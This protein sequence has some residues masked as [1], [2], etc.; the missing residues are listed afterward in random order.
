MEMFHANRQWSTRP[1]D[2]KFTSLEQMHAVTKAYAERAEE[3]TVSWKDLRIEADGKDV[4]LT[5]GSGGA[6]FTHYAFGQ[7]CARVG[8]PASYLR[9]LPAT[10]AAQNLNYGLKH[11]REDGNAQLLMHTNGN[12][13]VRAV[14]GEGYNRFWN[15]EVIMRLIDLSRRNHLVPAAPTF[16]QS[17][18]TEKALFASDHDMF[19]FLMTPER[20]VIDPVGKELYRG[21]IAVNSE[22]GDKSLKFMAFYFR[23]V[24]GNFIIWGA[25]QLVEVSMRHVGNINRKMVE[26]IVSVRKYLDADTT[27]E[28]ARFA[29]WSRQ[30]AG[31][32]DELLDKLFGVRSLGLSR[33]ALEASYD[34]V[35]V[36]QD[37]D[38]R[39]PWGIAQGIT[40]HSQ[41]LPYADERNTL[42]RA[43]GRLLEMAF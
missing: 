14:T 37:G 38:P 15:H 6:Q 11:N 21:I 19:A 27:L 7:F 12:K 23:D 20:Q 43:A 18:S 34:A 36:E 32:K 24:C 16:R 13:L 41:M 8:A 28:R 2:Q 22:V 3:R 26:A 4:Y 9:L 30:I 10:L 1:A 35:V 5:R 33:K 42:D 39:T 17:G 25:E 31:T 29:E 40:R